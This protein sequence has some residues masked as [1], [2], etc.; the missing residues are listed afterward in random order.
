M[1]SWCYA[2]CGLTVVSDWPVP[3][4]AAVSATSSGGAS[5]VQVIVREGSTRERGGSTFSVADGECRFSVAEAGEFVVSS[6]RRIVVRPHPAA[7]PELVRLF[8]L[9]SAW[10]AL[11]HQRGDMALHAGVTADPSGASAFCGPPAAGKSSTVT[12]LL[13]HGHALVSDD[14]TRLELTPH[15]PPLVWPSTPRLKLSAES[16]SAAVLSVPREAGHASVDEKVHLPWAG[17]RAT[18]PVPLQAAYVLNWGEPGVRRLRGIEAV[19]RFMAAATYRPALLTPAA[20][21]ARHWRQCVE[22]VKRVP[23]WELNRRRDWAS[24]EPLL[25]SLPVGSPAAES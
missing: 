11:L 2:H 9:G 16:L 25:A 7:D 14:L 17:R 15:G 1:S 20:A 3:E 12:W 21:M 4:L 24:M 10:G 6:G 8:L 22:V 23:V 19:S 18:G 5:D 13:Q